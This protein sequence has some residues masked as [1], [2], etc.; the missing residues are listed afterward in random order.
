MGTS[1]NG[2]SKENEGNSSKDKTNRAH[3]GKRFHELLLGRNEPVRI[4]NLSSIDEVLDELIEL[5]LKAY[6]GLEIYAYKTKDEVKEYLYW[7]FKRDPQ[8]IL[9]AKEGD[10]IIGFVATDKNWVWDNKKYGEIHELFVDPNYRGRGIGKVLFEK[11][12][13]RLLK[14]GAKNIGLWVGE[15]N[16]KA[17]KM[18][19]KEGFLQTDKRGKWIRMEKKLY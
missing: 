1:F 8:G 7:L 6:E 5:Y 16:E 18:Y 10:R 15:K 3:D 19:E 9:V 11:A 2:S 12:I 4:E 14:E 13:E 17:K